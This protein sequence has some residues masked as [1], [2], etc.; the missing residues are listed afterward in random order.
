MSDGLAALPGLFWRATNASMRWTLAGLVAGSIGVA[1]LETALLGGM[2]ALFRLL[3]HPDVPLPVIGTHLG[4]GAVPAVALGL[5]VLSLLR[6]VAQYRLVAQRNEVMAVWSRT[7]LRRLFSSQLAVPLARAGERDL[8]RTMAMVAEDLRAAF[9][10]VISPALQVASDIPIAAVI[11]TILLVFYPLLTLC[12]M[13]LFWLTHRALAVVTRWLIP[14]PRL[15]PRARNIV[16]EMLALTNH[17]LGSLKEIRVM[18]RAPGFR[19][20]MRR[21]AY[22]YGSALRQEGMEGIL[23]RAANEAALFLSLFVVVLYAALRGHAGA[24]VLPIAA[25][26]GSAG[27]R[28]LPILNQLARSLVEIRDHSASATAILTT[29]LDEPAG[30]RTARAPNVGAFRRSIRISGLACG[31]TLERPIVWGLDCDIPVGSRV[32]MT[33]RSGIGKTTLLDTLL[34]LRPPLAGSVEIDGRTML[35]A[36][37]TDGIWGCLVGYVP[38]DPAVANDTVRENLQFGRAGT[39]DDHLWWAL[40]LVGL[41]ALVRELPKGLDTLMG[42]RGMR[43]SGGQ[44]QRLCVARALLDRPALL[45]LD[46]ATAQID[47]RSEQQLFTSLA[48]ELPDLT[49]LIVT[50]RSETAQHCDIEI[51]IGDDGHAVAEQRATVVKAA[52]FVAD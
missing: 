47:S 19:A 6:A 39:H 21:V 44:R 22:R 38:Q 1:V 51:R 36:G 48:A 29:V 14:D 41:A 15:I 27:W 12:L 28:L 34:G 2:F 20:K 7:L 5:L 24:E 25:L 45:V 37:E 50:H 40:E 49:I 42:E 30:P 16:P 35:T 52:Q 23:A 18:R 11:I 43:L 26:I 4:S 32:V 33:G 9:R 13:V 31:Y 8:A 46:E 3:V 10:Q 17:A